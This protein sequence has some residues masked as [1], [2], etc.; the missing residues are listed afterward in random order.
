MN[1]ISA[2]SSVLLQTLPLLVAWLHGPDL[3]WLV[4]SVILTRLFSLVVMFWRCKVHVFQAHAPSISRQDAKSLLLFG[5]WV[6]I[7]A[8]VGPL[9]TVLDRFV[10]GAMVGA[11]A[12]TYY[13][14]PF[15]L[16]ER[17]TVLPAALTSALFPRFAS[18]SS[19]ERRELA[20]LAIRSLAA[21]MTPVI[22]IALLL[23]DPF[24]RLW[25]SPSLPPAPR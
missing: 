14:V 5:G 10:I 6:T 2:A 16:A 24:F 3:A 18:A 13:T 12:V 9:M 19:V 8:V 15:Q 1:I 17:S 22:V 25:I 21:V 23:V 7:T 20:T 4:P 11:S